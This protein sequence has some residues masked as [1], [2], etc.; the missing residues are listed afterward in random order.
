MTEDTIIRR[1]ES[2][3]KLSRDSNQKHQLD[4]L[5][6]KWEFLVSEEPKKFLNPDLTIKT[7]VIR[8]FRKLSVFIPDEPFFKPK[9]FN[10]RN[11]ISGARRGSIKLLKDSLRVIED[12]GYL[13][14]LKKYPCNH[15][16]NPNVFKYK[17]FYYTLRWLKHI[18]SLGLLKRTLEQQLSGDFIALDIG[19]SYGIFTYLLK[20]EFPGCHCVLLDFPEQ[21]ILAH[22]YLG[23]SYP[24][25][26]IAT[27]E[28]IRNKDKIDKEFFS[29]YD[30]VLI[31]WFFYKKISANS[32]DLVTNFASFGEMKREWFEFYIKNEPFLSAKYFFT[33]NRFQ[34]APTYDTDL[35]IM[36][37]PLKDFKKLHFAIC[38]IFSHTYLRKLLFFN[39]K[40]YFS[41]QY[42]EFIGEK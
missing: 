33:E 13:N 39:Q 37:Y 26:K 11:I 36:D 12:N 35:T 29:E 34:S 16:G 30:F 19:S 5:D 28:E 32:I 40:S 9:T 15:I 4:G 25:A 31:P 22:Y 17:G 42:F 20:K 10:L 41:S 18:Y 7:D 8:N 3:L 23:L 38:Q 21:L 14:L 2:D 1:I 27:Y 6:K 24:K